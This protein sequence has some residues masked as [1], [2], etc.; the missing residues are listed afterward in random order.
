MQRRARAW[1]CWR[2]PDP[3]PSLRGIFSNPL[4]GPQIIGVSSGAAMVYGISRIARRA[5]GTVVVFGEELAR[6]AHLEAVLARLRANKAM[7]GGS[8][9]PGRSAAAPVT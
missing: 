4:V 3:R 8:A 1:T 7:G 5:T 2:T 6:V 9:A